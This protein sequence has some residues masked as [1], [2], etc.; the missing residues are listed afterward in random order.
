ME[1]SFFK[2]VLILVI[3]LVIFGAGKL[4]GAM[5]EIG[6]SIRALKDGLKGDDAQKPAA[7]KQVADGDKDKNA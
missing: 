7:P 5:G 4:P 1:I 6:K 3:A 2:L